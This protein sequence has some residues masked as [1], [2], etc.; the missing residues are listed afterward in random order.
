LVRLWVEVQ[1][2]NQTELSSSDR[3]KRQFWV[4]SPNVNGSGSGTINQWIDVIPREKAAFMG[5]G[6]KAKKWKG[7]LHGLGGEWFNKSIRKNDILLI[8]HGRK[9]F[10]VGWGV[11][12]SNALEGSH[13]VKAPDG[14][15]L[16]YQMR[17]NLASF[18]SKPLFPR[19]LARHIPGYDSIATGAIYKFHE[20]KLGQKKV[21]DWLE[22]HIATKPTPID[23]GP[24]QALREE[25]PPPNH[26][27]KGVKSTVGS[28][29]PPPPPDPKLGLEGECL[30]YEYEKERLLAAGRR[31]LEKRVR[32]VAKEKGS[33]E[34]GYDILSFDP[35]NGTEKRIE[36]KTTRGA[37]TS[38][39]YLTGREV[40]CSEEHPGSYYLYRVYR[41]GQH[42]LFYKKKGRLGENF[43]LEPTEYR[44]HRR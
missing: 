35:V 11:V 17:R 8:A 9:R 39:F 29:N 42:P 2:E 28:G 36:V 1:M 32:H 13:V 37:A 6:R 40:R 14:S 3:K 44:A 10:V 20:N 15:L 31:D 41:F 22:K 30:V 12:I 27:K 21:C 43:G 33:A 18:K 5:Y 23:D 4:V 38:P 7:K 34:T 19:E 26:T 25:P 16:E 24:S